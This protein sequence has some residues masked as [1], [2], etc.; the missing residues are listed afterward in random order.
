MIGIALG[1]VDFTDLLMLLVALTGSVIAWRWKRGDFY[2]AVAE[3]KTA[4]TGRLREELDQRRRM[5]DITPIVTTLERVVDSLDKTASVLDET[6][7]KVRDLNGSLKA[8]STAVQALADRLVL[9][10]AARALLAE[11]ARQKPRT[12]AK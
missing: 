2:K 1:S 6:V 5:T 8:H 12:R 4:E 7:E 11:S 9:D 3:E 10:E